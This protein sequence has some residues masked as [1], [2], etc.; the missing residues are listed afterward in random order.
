MREEHH[1]LRW[2]FLR[3]GLARAAVCVPA[4]HSH[5][6]LLLLLVP[7]V[8]RLTGCRKP[9][10]RPL[11]PGQGREEGSFCWICGL[12]FLS[13]TARTCLPPCSFAHI[14]VIFFSNRAVLTPP[15]QAPPG[16]SSEGGGRFG[17]KLPVSFL[18]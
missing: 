5:D 1:A 16:R 10:F 18:C 4:F 12:G 2:S 14:E 17:D 6:V 9:D 8:Q 15:H 13:Q 11:T 7:V 3:L